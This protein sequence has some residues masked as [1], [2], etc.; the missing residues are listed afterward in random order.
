[1]AK[2]ADENN[3]EIE[4]GGTLLHSLPERSASVLHSGL[5]VCPD[6]NYCSD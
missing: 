2:L 6:K 3:I 4:V 1:M 5:S